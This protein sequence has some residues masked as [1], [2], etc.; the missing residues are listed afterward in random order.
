M[1][2]QKM[3]YMH[4]IVGSKIVA[5]AYQLF[6]CQG[7]LEEEEPEN[8]DYKERNKIDTHRRKLH[9]EREITEKSEGTTED[10]SAKRKI[11]THQKSEGIK[12]KF[13]HLHES[14]RSKKRDSIRNNR[15]SVYL[16]KKSATLLSQN[17]TEAEDDKTV[18]MEHVMATE[19]PRLPPKLSE[20]TVEVE[21]V[22]IRKVP[23]YV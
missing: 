19:K 17:P 23:V 7:I 4:R 15:R 9:E 14:V 6:F 1:Y 21:M 3:T 18:K 12:E 22:P 5:M 16:R 2:P 20:I 10:A 11:G 8:L 13:S